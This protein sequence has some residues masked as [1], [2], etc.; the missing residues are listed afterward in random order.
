MAILLPALVAMGLG[1]ICFR[2]RVTGVY[3]AVITLALTLL[4]QLVVYNQAQV[5][6]GFNGLTDLAW[7][8]VGKWEFDPFML[9]TYYLI[10]ILF[11]LVL[12]GTRWLVTT[13]AGLI[14]QAIRDDE[15]RVRYLGY[16]VTHYK[17]FF[18][19]VSAAIGGLA[20][21]LYVIASEFASPTFFDIGF[22]IS[23]VVWAAVGGRHSLLGA[24]V[25]AILL[26]MVEAFLSETELFVEA[27]Q[28]VTGGIFIFF[29]LAIPRGIAGF[30]QAGVDGLLLRMGRPATAGKEKSD[31]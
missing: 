3:V 1:Y 7:F 22:S 26:N 28:L 9:R 4:V 19:G 6:A 20:G 2:A 21:M 29:V 14:L 12:M 18:F 31:T 11:A 23:M 17:L 10:A 16:D 27:W 13:R 5:T 15:D 8:A 30:L 25:G 24:A